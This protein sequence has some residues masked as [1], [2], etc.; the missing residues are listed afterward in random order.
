MFTRYLTCTVLIAG[1]I[2]GCSMDSIGVRADRPAPPREVAAD[3]LAK[4]RA[5]LANGHPEE[6]IGLYEGVLTHVEPGA[7]GREEA[8]YGLALASLSVNGKAHS[9]DKAKKALALLLRES[10]ESGRRAEASALLTVVDELRRERSQVTSLKRSLATREKE[11]EAVR[12][13]LQSK[14]EALDNLRKALLKR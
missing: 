12:G 9:P 4:A 11:L 6:S 10:P 3:D 5:A 8:L 14:E 7:P 1:L 13:E 2:S